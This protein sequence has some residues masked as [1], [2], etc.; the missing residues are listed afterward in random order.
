[1]NAALNSA[2]SANPA[3][4][5]A[6]R[7]RPH[8]I[9]PVRTRRA[10]RFQVHIATALKTLANTFLAALRRM[11]WPGPRPLAPARVC[12]YKI[13][14]LGDIAC[15]IPAIHAI[16]RMFPA[17]HLTLVT[18]P[19]RRGM[20]GAADLLRGVG[21]L[22]EILA[23]H[24]EDIAGP[25]ARLRWVAA[26]RARRFDAW[27]ELPAVDAPL[28]M[29]AR[30]MIAAR[31]AGARWGFGWRYE[32]IRIFARAQSE[33]LEFPNETTRLV[34]LLAA[35]GFTVP[36]PENP[37]EDFPLEISAAERAA[38]DRILAAEGIANTPLAALAPGA[39][40]PANRWPAARFIEVG[41]ELAARG[42]RIVVIGSAQEAVL[43]GEIA[44]AIGSDA[45]SLAGKTS[46]RESC[47]VLRRC[48]LL[49]CNDSGVQHLA[50]P[51]GTP[52][53]SIFS[54]RDFR[55][56][57]FPTGARNVT[58]RKWVPC[59]TCFLDRCPYDNRCVALVT[60][61]EALAAATGILDSAADSR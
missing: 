51:A 55:G 10:A 25:R 60:A 14:N 40:A 15:A 31:I 24:S 41:R 20:P 46:V 54:S 50:A 37:S 56:K 3:V 42:F 16:R 13:G 6:T 26:M 36:A 23:Y 29:L 5:R 44:A 2:N 4:D 52:C 9:E 58:L 61:A 1:M 53:V 7:T 30:N 8:V 12:I 34:R 17:A 48:A 59:H 33:L 39:K 11:L 19:G 28:A 47:E 38:V 27:I 57:W 35:G 32:R 18:S 22:D 49:V 45:R 43:C 21:W